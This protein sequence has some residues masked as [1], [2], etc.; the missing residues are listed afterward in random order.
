[1]NRTVQHPHHR[2]RVVTSKAKTRTASLIHCCMTLAL[3]GTA[4]WAQSSGGDYEVTRSVI[5]SGGGVSSG[6][7]FSLQGTVG[8]PQS[9]TSTGGEFAMR[10]GFW[11][12]V[13]SGPAADPLF[14]N[15]FES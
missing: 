9:G 2:S 15:G 7:G 13:A 5:A 4:A 14:S 12:P 3:A 6:G 8:Q 10:G 1:M 11:A